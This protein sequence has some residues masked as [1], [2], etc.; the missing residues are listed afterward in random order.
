MFFVQQILIFAS[1][2]L[3][4]KSGFNFEDEGN[5]RLLRIAFCIASTVELLVNIYIF[6]KLQTKSE[7]GGDDDDYT[8]KK[9]YFPGPPN[10]L[11]PTPKYDPKPRTVSEYEQEKSSQV[12]NIALDAATMPPHHNT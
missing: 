11:D 3:A 5:I 4:N 2:T 6:K 1:I 9:M 7:T 10:F 8:N 12:P